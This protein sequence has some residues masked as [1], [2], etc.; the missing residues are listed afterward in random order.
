MFR[1]GAGL[2]DLIPR[3][4]QFPPDVNQVIQVFNR[5]N[6]R[7]TDLRTGLSNSDCGT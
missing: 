5:E 1:S 6:V 2:M 4:R 3:S 7:K